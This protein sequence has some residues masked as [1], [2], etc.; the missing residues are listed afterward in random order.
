MIGRSD[1]SEVFLGGQRGLLAPALE[2][3][4]AVLRFSPYVRL[5]GMQI[6]TKTQIQLRFRR[7]GGN[8]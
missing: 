7:P 1:D 2:A 8:S 3:D 6:L 5:V 4:T